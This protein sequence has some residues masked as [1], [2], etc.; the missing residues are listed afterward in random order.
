MNQAEALAMV[1][2]SILFA[3]LAV[4]LNELRLMVRDIPKATLVRPEQARDIPLL[5]EMEMEVDFAVRDFD[6]RLAELL[7]AS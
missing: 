4:C 5:E 1:G 6:R 3:I 7:Y 2:M